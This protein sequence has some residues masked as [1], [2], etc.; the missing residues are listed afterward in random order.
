ML[1]QGP[2]ALY[3]TVKAFR[4]R[5]RLMKKVKASLD[6]EG[7]RRLLEEASGLGAETSLL[8]IAGLDP[9]VAMTEEFPKYSQLLTRLPL[10][11]TFQVYNSDQI[12]WRDP[13]A[14]HLTYYLHARRI[15]EDVFP[16]QLPDTLSNYRSLWYTTYSDKNLPN[17]LI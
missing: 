2:F 1:D 8:Y 10:V 14:A 13:I 4:R 16:D 12:Q 11:Q 6:L 7:G 5:E 17:Y 3:L 9:L 15:V